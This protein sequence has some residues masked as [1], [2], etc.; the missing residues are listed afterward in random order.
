[1]NI[2][3]VVISL[4]LALMYFINSG[5]KLSHFSS[6]E[7]Q[8]YYD[9]VSP[10]LLIMIDTFRDRWGHP[11]YIS[12]ASGAVGRHNGDSD[13]SQHNLDKWGEVR[14]LDLMP[15]VDGRSMTAADAE[16]AVSLAK[17]IGFTGI[18]VYSDTSPY[19]LLHVDVREDRLSGSPATW[20][21][22]AGI[23]TGLAEVLA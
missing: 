14:A 15:T 23:Y 13:T 17:E 5:K 6:N 19:W 7:F 2:P 8:G 4:A 18:G 9:Q 1:M 3:A 22:I 12:P 16:R 10:K 20:G 21:R 11:V